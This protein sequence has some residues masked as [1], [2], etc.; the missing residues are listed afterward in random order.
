MKMLLK[1]TSSFLVVDFPSPHA[2]LLEAGQGQ[3]PVMK[4]EERARDVGLWRADAPHGGCVITPLAGAR[5]RATRIADDMISLG[6]GA[7]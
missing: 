2:A 5:R 4:T 6:S 7:A 1:P 3:P